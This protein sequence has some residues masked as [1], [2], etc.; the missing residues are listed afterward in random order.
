[1][2]PPGGAIWLVPVRLAL[3]DQDMQIVVES[4]KDV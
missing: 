3:A 4:E 2:Y 1:M